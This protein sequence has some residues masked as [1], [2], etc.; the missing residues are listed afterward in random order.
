MKIIEINDYD[1][2][3]SLEERWT[4]V[5]QRCTHNIFSTWEWLQTG[6]KH[7]GNY[8]KLVLLLAE[9]HNK[10][11]GI[12]PLMYSVQTIFGLRRGKIEFMGAPY[13]DYN[14]FI[15]AE[16]REECL[17]L[18]I[19]YIYSLPEKWDC[20]DLLDIP[21]NAEC[22]P[23]LAKVSKNLTMIHECPHMQLP[24]SYEKFLMG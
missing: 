9:E 3:L 16:K 15:I 11:I 8:K 5:L 17:K 22:L 6:W 19:D 24:E 14:N 1:D 18:F 21:E 23:F 12:A 2:F 20:I 7:F 10:I 13:S 4:E